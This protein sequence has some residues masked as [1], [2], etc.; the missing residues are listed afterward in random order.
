M[1]PRAQHKSKCCFTA[2]RRTFWNCFSWNIWQVSNEQETRATTEA[3]SSMPG[4]LQLTSPLL[5]SPQQP[6]GQAINL[7]T[8]NSLGSVQL[9]PES[10]LSFLSICIHLKSTQW[11]PKAVETISNCSGLKLKSKE[12]RRAIRARGWNSETLSR[13][14]LLVLDV[15]LFSC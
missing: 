9:F 6:T 11:W 2:Q 13:A 10:S 1:P 8:R 15:L 12:N 3:E 7:T 5:F 4:C 14:V